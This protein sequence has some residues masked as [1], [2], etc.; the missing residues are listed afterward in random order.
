MA[1]SPRKGATDLV[2]F[3]RSLAAHSQME[4]ADSH[5]FAAVARGGSPPAGF[6]SRP[7]AFGVAGDLLSP[8]VKKDPHHQQG[9]F[10]SAPAGIVAPGQ[11][12]SDHHLCPVPVPVSRPECRLLT[13][14]HSDGR[15]LG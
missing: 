5:R 8:L 13:L 3:C 1:E 6:V 12:V 9:Y 4:N 14:S 10:L 7:D 2:E 15:G 11:G